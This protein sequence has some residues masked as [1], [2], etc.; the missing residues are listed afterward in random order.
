MTYAVHIKVVTEPNFELTDG[1]YLSRWIT[2]PDRTW[3]TTLK[4]LNELIRDMEGI[5]E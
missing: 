4:E 5:A 3:E 1:V 2:L